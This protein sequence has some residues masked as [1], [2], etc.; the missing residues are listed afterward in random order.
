M[1]AISDYI[2]LVLPASIF[3]GS[4]CECFN[5]YQNLKDHY[6]DIFV[7]FS[8][9]PLFLTPW[10][11]YVHKSQYAH[12]RKFW[13]RTF[14]SANSEWLFRWG[15][16]ACAE[17]LVGSHFEGNICEFWLKTRKTKVNLHKF[18]VCEQKRRLK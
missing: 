4:H 18:H 14:C 16:L 8:T 9:K 13:E 15:A 17:C 12:A 7:K 3:K 1:A 10:N 11:A 5:F 2:N 6:F